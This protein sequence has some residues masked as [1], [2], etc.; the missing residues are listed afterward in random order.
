ML[1]QLSQCQRQ[2]AWGGVVFGAKLLPALSHRGQPLLREEAQTE[3]SLHRETGTEF[4]QG[5]M[6]FRHIRPCGVPPARADG[7][8]SPRLAE[9]SAKVA[10]KERGAEDAFWTRVT[11]EG[12]P[13][14]EDVHDSKGRLLVTFLYRAR[15]DT[16][17]VAMFGAP[18]GAPGGPGAG[19]PI[20]GYARLERLTGTSVFAHSALVDPA[21]RI[22]YTLVPGD[23]FG[24]PSG[25]ADFQ[26]RL[27]LMRHDALNRHPQRTGSRIDLPKAPPQP[28]LVVHRDTPAAL[29]HSD[30]VD[31]RSALASPRAR[32]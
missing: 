15:P 9:L 7:P 30:R 22:I 20:P 5:P 26:K 3:T 1:P 29:E 17:V 25:F 12:T 24:P 16:R 18:D 10:A 31:A 11:D 14:V 6:V 2:L 19:G 8:A 32:R 21:A 13:M 23:G 28:L 27:P 4:P